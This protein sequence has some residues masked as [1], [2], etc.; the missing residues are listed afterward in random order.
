[1]SKSTPYRCDYCARVEQRATV[2]WGAQDDSARTAGWRIG[3]TA[4]KDR[5]VICPECAGTDEEYWD[6]MTLNV[7]YAAGIDA[8]NQAWG[9]GQ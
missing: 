9:G 7:A 8:G 4:K 2:P 1:M 3:P 6:R 5:N